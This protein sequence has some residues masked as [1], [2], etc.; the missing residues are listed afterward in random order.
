VLPNG[1]VAPD[2]GAGSSLARTIVSLD[3]STPSLETEADIERL[4]K[5]LGRFQPRDR[6]RPLTAALRA[7]AA[8]ATSAS[9][10]AA[11]DVSQIEK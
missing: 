8:M 3:V 11:R 7:Y 10:G 2:R 1:A 4:L 6:K 9:T 5:E